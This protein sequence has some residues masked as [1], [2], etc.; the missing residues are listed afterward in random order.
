MSW[1]KYYDMYEVEKKR[2]MY[3]RLS[4]EK[5]SSDIL[6]A[7]SDDAIIAGM[8]VAYECQ[9]KGIR[10]NGVPGFYKLNDYWVFRLDKGMFVPT[11]NQ[12]GEII[13]LQMRKDYGKLRYMTVSSK[14]LEAGPTTF[15]SRPHFPLANCEISKDTMM[16][17]T[18]GPLK[19]DVALDILNNQG[20]TNYA[21]VAVHGVNN[22]NELEDIFTRLQQAGVKQIFNAFD[23]D[24][25]TNIHVQ[26][27]CGKI[28]DLAA[29]KG[30]VMKQLEWD[31]AFKGIDDFLKAQYIG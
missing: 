18:E 14:G 26:E 1:F 17:I 7:Y 24:R 27:A 8:C 29:S 5:N 15:I 12:K 21:F 31:C 9:K 23:M 30:L 3:G 19:A 28:D 16:L 13:A 20:Y 2:Y 25:T 11:R 4:I 6:R 10:V 22:R